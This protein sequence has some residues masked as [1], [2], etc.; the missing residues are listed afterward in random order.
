MKRIIL[1][2]FLALGLVVIFV[3]LAKSQGPYFTDW[4]VPVPVT[5]LNTTFS[6]SPNSISRDGLSL[7]INYM[8]PATGTGEDI[9]IAKRPDT[10]SSWGTPVKVPN[11]NSNNNDRHGFISPDGHWLYFASNR[12]GGL[13]GYDIYVSWRKH[14][15]DDNG[16]QTPVNLA[17]VNSTGFEVGP[18]I[19][20]DESGVTHL[21]FNHAPS[22][23]TI[24]DIYTSVLGPN[25]FEPPAAVSELNTTWHEGASYLRKDGREIYFPRT[26][27]GVQNVMTSTRSSIY[28]FWLPPVYVFDRSLIGDPAITFITNPVLSWD[29]KTLY[30]GVFQTGVDNGNAN[31]YVSYREKAQGND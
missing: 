14:V 22:P 8:N 25:G 15:N 28:D 13:G 7:Y 2:Y 3:G 27:S 4:S 1:S 17:A 16:W 9:Y 30:I 29:A 20:E 5:E 11:I 24:A 6:E 21:Y 19:F 31:I 26:E 18:R 12:P 23:S 10:D